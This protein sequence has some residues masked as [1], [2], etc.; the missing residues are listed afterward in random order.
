MEK[1]T[2]AKEETNKAQSIRQPLME[3]SIKGP[4]TNQ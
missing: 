2:M 1:K 3:Q 4:E